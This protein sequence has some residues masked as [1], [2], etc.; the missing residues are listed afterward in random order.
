MPNSVVSYRRILV[1]TA[2]SWPTTDAGWTS[3][4]DISAP[5]CAEG[6]SLEI[7]YARLTEVWGKRKLPYATSVANA[8]Y[9]PNLPARYVRLL[10][11][12]NGGSIA[13]TTPDVAG[14]RQWT[15]FWWGIVLDQNLSPDNSAQA[16]TVNGA[17]SWQCAGLLADLDIQPKRGF[18]LG[19]TTAGA[20]ALWD[21]GQA[22]GFNLRP[23]GERSAI[24][25]DIGGG[26]DVYV[27]DRTTPGTRWT[28]RDAVLH[29]LASRRSLGGAPPWATSGQNDAVTL[30]FSEPWDLAGLSYL[31]RLGRILA[32]RRGVSFRCRVVSHVPYLY[33]TTTVPSAITVGGYTLPANTDTISLTIAGS[34]FASITRLHEDHSAVLDEIGVE[35]I[36]RPWMARS[37]QWI[38][39]GGGDLD[40]DWTAGEETSW[41]AASAAVRESE[42]LCHVWRRFKLKATPPS[43]WVNNKRVLATS[44]SYGTNGE[45]GTQTTDTTVGICSAGIELT[46][47]LPLYAGYDYTSAVASPDKTRPLQGPRVFTTTTST[48]V[49]RTNDWP[50]LIDGHTITIGTDAVDAVAIR[51]AINIS[52]GKLACTVGVIEP[53]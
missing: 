5:E 29:L 43:L 23:D 50:V 7:G 44:A 27:H 31:S 53:L 3:R 30:V 6:W 15:A 11:Q 20:A 37:F 24:V 42:A 18:E 8:D 10:C 45:D 25:Y 16:T 47:D 33:V 35:S 41:D 40:K 52:G 9:T 48:W 19:V 32:P 2:S 38:L 22:L 4:Y 49:D 26:F 13:V 17:T 36:S 1:Q 21:P 51:A 28:A 46:R 14:S 34:T 39:A 12:D